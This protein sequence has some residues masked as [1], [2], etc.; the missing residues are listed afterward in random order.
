MKK[1]LVVDDEQDVRVYLTR[2]FEENGYQV[3]CAGDGDK[4]LDALGADKPDLITLDISMPHKSGAK[5][6]RQVRSEPE[7]SGIPVVL[8]TGV[9]GPTGDPA[10]TERFYSTRRGVPRPDGFVAKPIDRDEMIAVVKRLIG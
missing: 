9:T 3:S 6:Y 4:A 2:L 1:I 5:F 8:V 7:L 10:D